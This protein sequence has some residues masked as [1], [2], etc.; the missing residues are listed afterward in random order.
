[1][2]M[3]DR[4]YMFGDQSTFGSNWNGQNMPKNGQKK[5]YLLVH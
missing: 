3:C 1:M 4:K 2:E 5:K